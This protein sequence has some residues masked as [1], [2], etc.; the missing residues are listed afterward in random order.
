MNSNKFDFF[1]IPETNFETFIRMWVLS[2]RFFL[3]FLFFWFMSI[4]EDAEKT[5]V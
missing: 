5:N 4:T 3:N 1:K 2:N